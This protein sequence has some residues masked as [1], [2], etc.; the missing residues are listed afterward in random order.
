MVEI[1]GQSESGLKHASAGRLNWGWIE[2]SA[3]F[4][5]RFGS[6]LPL[7]IIFDPTG[8]IAYSAIGPE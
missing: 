7:D 5:Q 3:P 2:I 1:D 8:A 6:Q 4:A